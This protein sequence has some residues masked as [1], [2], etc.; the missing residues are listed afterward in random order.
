MQAIQHPPGHHIGLALVYPKIVCNSGQQRKPTQTEAELYPS[1][2]M[3]AKLI[4]T[5]A[6]TAV[7]PPKLWLPTATLFQGVKDTATM[8]HVVKLLADWPHPWHRWQPSI[9]PVP[10]LVARLTRDG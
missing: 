6:P 5:F 10:P 9:N 1:M 7:Q 2:R 3:A 8:V 4:W